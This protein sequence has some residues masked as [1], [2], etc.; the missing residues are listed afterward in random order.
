M[1]GRGLAS[2]VSVVCGVAAAMADV[3]AAAIAALSDPDPAARLRGAIGVCLAQRDDPSAAL[4]AVQAAGW[5]V[6]MPPGSGA[7]F[8]VFQSGDIFLS[9]GADAAVCSVLSN[10]HPTEAAAAALAEVLAAAGI[11]PVSAGADANGCP[12]QD[13]Q[14]G[15]R[16]G[17][18]GAG[19]DYPCTS[20]RDSNLFIYAG[21]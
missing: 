20:D 17:L 9:L 8:A 15:R 3:P 12:V 11:A 16:A 19:T 6:Q 13:L 7:G 18:Y 4:Q 2:A 21:P 10:A 1:I 14:D 5:D